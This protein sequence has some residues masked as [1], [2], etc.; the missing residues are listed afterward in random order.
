MAKILVSRDTSALLFCLI[1]I[2]FQDEKNAFYH[3]TALPIVFSLPGMYL[4]IT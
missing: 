1:P 3:D 2:G 4:C